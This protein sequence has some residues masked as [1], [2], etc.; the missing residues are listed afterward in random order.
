LCVR[1]ENEPEALST[2]VP[3]EGAAS[4]WSRHPVLQIDGA[5]G[6]DPNEDEWGYPG[7]VGAQREAAGRRLS[8]RDRIP[9]KKHAMEDKLQGDTDQSAARGGA[10][11]G[12]FSSYY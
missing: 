8:R 2:V 10:L 5:S 1:F 6:F 12:K 9:S 3:A 4:P 11:H 7:P